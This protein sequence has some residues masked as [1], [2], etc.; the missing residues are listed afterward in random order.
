MTLDLSASQSSLTMP[1]LMLRIQLENRSFRPVDTKTS[2]QSCGICL[3]PWQ[4][5]DSFSAAQRRVTEIGGTLG[6]TSRTDHVEIV[7]RELVGLLPHLQR[8]AG[9]PEMQVRLSRPAVSF[10]HELQ[11][12]R[13]LNGRLVPESFCLRC[14]V[15]GS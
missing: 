11:R 10:F 8:Q 15:I 14:K 5:K 3:K 6:A 13:P 12:V 4:S 1:L 2:C 7:A 9:Q